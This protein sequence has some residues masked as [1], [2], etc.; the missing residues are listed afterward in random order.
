MEWVECLRWI[1][2]TAVYDGDTIT[3][4]VLLGLSFVARDVKLR[5]FGID[6]PEVRGIERPDGLVTR[7]WL[8]ERILGKTILAK[9]FGDDCNDKGKYGRHLADIYEDLDANQSLNQEMVDEGLAEPAD[10]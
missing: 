3:S 8:R 2:V 7:D 6:A 10:Y 4:N 1:E 9:F 5:L